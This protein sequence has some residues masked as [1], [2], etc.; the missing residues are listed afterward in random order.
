M[1]HNVLLN[2]IF[3]GKKPWLFLSPELLGIAV[4]RVILD[5]TINKTLDHIDALTRMS[6]RFVRGNSERRSLSFSSVFS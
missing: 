1:S 3:R 2:G 4:A 5:P 6:V